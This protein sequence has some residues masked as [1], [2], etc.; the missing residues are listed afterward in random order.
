MTSYDFLLSPL[1][2]SPIRKEVSGSLLLPIT[3]K[4]SLGQPHLSS[5]SFLTWYSLM[6]C[7]H[8]F[9]SRHTTVYRRVTANKS[10]LPACVHIKDVDDALWGHL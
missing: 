2:S 6:L 4:P 10:K 1:I 9:R 7:T 3:H 5:I 8:L